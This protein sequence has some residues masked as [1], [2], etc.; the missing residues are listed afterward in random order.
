LAAV[1]GATAGLAA[2]VG[3][4]AGFAAV[5]GAEA[6]GLTA[7]VGAAAGLVVV[8]VATVALA[9]VAGAAAGFTGVGPVVVLAGAAAG[10]AA[11]DVVL[12]FVVSGAVARTVAGAEV[13]EVLVVAL[14]TCAR[15]TP[16][17]V[18]AT[19]AAAASVRAARFT[20]PAGRSEVRSGSLVRI[21]G[22]LLLRRFRFRGRLR[23][24]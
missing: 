7:V 10:F 14:E 19:K 1:V 17:S 4:T 23:E 5:V 2:V 8:A 6:T 15:A 18:P 12:V 9:A 22:S 13:G 24:R 16:A 20:R 3:A 11:V 21:G